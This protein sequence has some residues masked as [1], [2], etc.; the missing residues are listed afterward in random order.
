MNFW[1]R[2][3][4]V[5]VP[6]NKS[7]AKITGKEIKLH[8]KRKAL[9]YIEILFILQLITVCIVWSCTNNIHANNIEVLFVIVS[10]LFALILYTRKAKDLHY[11][12]IFGQFMCFAFIPLRIYQTGG[13][14][15][16]ILFTLIS[17]I[18]LSYSIVGRKMGH[19]TLIWCFSLVMF[20]STY[21]DVG[22][23]PEAPNDILV[24]SSNFILNILIAAVLTNFN[25]A[26]GDK[27]ISMEK[28]YSAEIIMKR[29]AHELRNDLNVAVGFLELAKEDKADNSYL[30]KVEKS[31]ENINL[32]F[33]S[34]EDMADQDNLI[35]NLKKLEKEI[36]IVSPR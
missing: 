9:I 8:F 26:L 1:R 30:E 22:P 11:V 17:H 3:D 29:I 12:I 27:L 20:F 35:D 18:I 4:Q 31:L 25:R 13:I 19:I 2:L 23:I 32:T 28:N 34:M 5:L 33:K 6:Q 15:S 24:I 7:I 14:H 16:P 36:R 10:S 21:K